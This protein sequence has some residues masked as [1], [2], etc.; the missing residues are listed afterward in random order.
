[1]RRVPRLQARNTPSE[2]GGLTPTLGEGAKQ[3]TH[4]R[5]RLTPSRPAERP[6]GALVPKEHITRIR[7]RRTDITRAKDKIPKQSVGILTERVAH[8]IR[9]PPFSSSSVSS[10]LIDSGLW[11]SSLAVPAVVV[12]S[13]IAR[14]LSR[15]MCHASKAHH[16]R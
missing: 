5:R 6:C 4:E 3:D 11:F 12:F 8:T 7:S 10:F 1:M 14:A 16:T 9:S 13:P 15:V 2:T